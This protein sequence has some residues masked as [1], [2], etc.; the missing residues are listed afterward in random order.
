MALDSTLNNVGEVIET[1]ARGCASLDS[2]D[3][4]V[5]GAVEFNETDDGKLGSHRAPQVQVLV[6]ARE[7]VEQDTLVR[8]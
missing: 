7:P 3:D 6:V 1:F 5:F 8:G 2:F 4:D